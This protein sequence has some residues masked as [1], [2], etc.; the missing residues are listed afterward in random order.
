MVTK[1]LRQPSAWHT[2]ID[3]PH[4]ERS[5]EKIE[6]EIFVRF[7]DIIVSAI[8]TTGS[9]SQ[10]HHDPIVNLRNMAEPSKRAVGITLL[11]RLNFNIAD[12]EDKK[13]ATMQQYNQAKK[14]LINGVE[15]TLTKLLNQKTLL[16]QQ[17]TRIV[18]NFKN[19]KTPEGNCYTAYG[20]RILLE[21]HFSATDHDDHESPKISTRRKKKLDS[22]KPKKREP[23]KGEI[24]EETLRILMQKLNL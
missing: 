5:L 2:E 22:E 6:Q 11:P 3:D 1:E 24:R 16:N 7:T 18:T 9:I 14:F 4:H 20:I 15:N 10:I 13:T 17:E 23:T 19:M 8:V 21:Q 12:M